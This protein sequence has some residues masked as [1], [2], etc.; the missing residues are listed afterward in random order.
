MD[1]LACALVARHPDDAQ[2]SGALTRVCS[3]VFVFHVLVLRFLL[4]FAE[5]QSS[6]FMYV[7]ERLCLSSWTGVQL[8][9]AQAPGAAYERQRRGCMKVHCHKTVRACGTGAQG[10]AA[11][12]AAPQAA[13][14]PPAAAGGRRD[15]RRAGVAAARAPRAAALRGGVPRDRAR[16]ARPGAAPAHPQPA[17]QK[18][19]SPVL[20][21]VLSRRKCETVLRARRRLRRR[22]RRRRAHRRRRPRTACVRASFGC[23]AAAL[24]NSAAAVAAAAR[25]RCWSGAAWGL[26]RAGFSR[27]FHASRRLSGRRA[28]VVLLCARLR[29]AVRTA[30]LVPQPPHSLPSIRS[31]RP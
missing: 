13:D 9:S 4:A 30:I 31:C 20:A 22:R 17:R 24:P 7:A 26:R 27:V 11:E 5:K 3:C 21:F 16:A 6:A 15:G 8:D 14:W 1:A 12:P 23:C 18:W 2:V 25:L 29:Q 10:G 28:L 19:Q